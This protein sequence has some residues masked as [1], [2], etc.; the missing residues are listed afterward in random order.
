MMPDGVDYVLQLVGPGGGGRA[1]DQR[2]AAE[3]D[4]TTCGDD[5]GGRQQ[6]IPHIRPAS[7]VSGSRDRSG[8]ECGGVHWSLLPLVSCEQISAAPCQFLSVGDSAF[9]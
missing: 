4:S 3:I 1:R 2:L 7:A 6:A 5:V 8:A 9:E